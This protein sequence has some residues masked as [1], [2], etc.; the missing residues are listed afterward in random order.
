MLP[1]LSAGITGEPNSSKDVITVIWSLLLLF[2]NFNFQSLKTDVNVSY[3][4]LKVRSKNIEK[5]L[6]VGILPIRM[7]RRI[8]KPVVRI[9]G[10]RSGSGSVPKCQGYTTLV[11]VLVVQENG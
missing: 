9:H 7:Q 5:N 2:S 6:F 1:R 11:N 3:F 8:C 4:L 10:P